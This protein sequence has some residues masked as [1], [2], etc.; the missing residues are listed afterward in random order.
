ML[1]EVG[2]GLR[3]VVL[4]D[5]EV[6]GLEMR[7]RVAVGVG[8][9]DVDYDDLSGGADGGTSGACAGAASGRIRRTSA[10]RRQN[11]RSPN[12]S[13]YRGKTEQAALTGAA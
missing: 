5:G 4:G 10:E 1:V 8:D 2:D 7:D 6:R 3:S 13:K 12:G 11:M 9:A